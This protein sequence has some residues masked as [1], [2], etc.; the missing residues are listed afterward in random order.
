MPASPAGQ[1][2]LRQRQQDVAGVVAA[3][4]D[5]EEHPDHEHDQTEPQVEP[6]RPGPRLVAAARVDGDGRDRQQQP[7]Q[8][9]VR[10]AR[11]ADRETDRPAPPGDRVE[12]ARH[13]HP[14]RLR[15]T[16]TRPAAPSTSTARA[17]PIQVGRAPPSSSDGLGPEVARRRAGGDLGR[18][19]HGAVRGV[20]GRASVASSGVPGE[21]DRWS[22]GMPWPPTSSARRGRTPSVVGAAVVAVV[23]ASPPSPSPPLPPLPVV[24]R[25]RCR[26]ARPT[27]R[28]GSWCGGRAHSPAAAHGPRPRATRTRRSRRPGRSSPPTPWL[29]NRHSPDLPSDHHR[30]QNESFSRHGR[31]SGRP[32]TLQT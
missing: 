14:V 6:E 9:R 24:A 12:V 7:E 20:R 10:R 13:P 23:A 3:D 28:T 17:R 19:G 32:V 27:A 4:E 15:S 26:T 25:R 29:E 18:A 2:D 5:P 8:E 21:A 30:L 16:V 11:G 1:R 31:S 22:S